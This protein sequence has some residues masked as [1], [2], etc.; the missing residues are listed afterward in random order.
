MKCVK[1]NTNSPIVKIRRN[2]I[3]ILK[4]SLIRPKLRGVKLIAGF[5]RASLSERDWRERKRER[6]GGGGFR[7]TSTNR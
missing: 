7:R 2:A 5:P 6:E 3:W 1:F 4:P